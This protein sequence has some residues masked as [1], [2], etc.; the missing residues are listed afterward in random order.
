MFYLENDNVAIREFT[1]NDIENKVKWIND[2]ENNQYLHYDL[3]LRYEKTL[4]WFNNKSKNRLDCVIEYNRT[5]VGLVGLI[6]IDEK[7]QKAEFYI[8]MGCHEFK[9]RGIATKATELILIYAF[10]QLKLNKVFLN[11]DEDN[12]PACKL[13]EKI[14]FKQE[15][16]FIKD[17]FHRGRFINRL[18]Y[19]IFLEDFIK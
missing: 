1:C 8:S 14:G 11:V 5:P 3:P 18:H 6:D 10:E 16:K 17:L 13:Y 19:A 7:N 12:I 2:S 4:N 9:K 15:G